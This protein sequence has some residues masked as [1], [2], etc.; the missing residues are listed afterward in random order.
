MGAG[1]LR[2]PKVGRA[3]VGIAAA[4]MLSVTGSGR[5]AAQE[6]G[7]ASAG[8]E[9][10]TGATTASA[11]IEKPRARTVTGGTCR[12]L[13]NGTFGGVWGP[14]SLPVLAFTIGPGSAMADQMHASKSPFAGPGQYRSVI[15]AVYLG[16]SATEDA[17]YGLGTVT[18]NAD[19]RTGSFALDDGSASG[20]WDCGRVLP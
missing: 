17:Y 16:K 10:P 20:H 11:R 9:S 5:A 2:E 19:R 13:S 1:R 4:V 15:I 18:V 12:V 6:G 7:H 14:S 3:L 8:A